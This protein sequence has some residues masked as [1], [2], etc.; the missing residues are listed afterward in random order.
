MAHTLSC[1]DPMSEATKDIQDSD[2][3]ASVAALIGDTGKPAAPA[4]PIAPSDAT[5][6][7][8]AGR[9]DFEALA[10]EAVNL[11][12]SAMPPEETAPPPT[13]SVEESLA[14]AAADLANSAAAVS[15]A[16]VTLA[17]APPSESQDL[18]KAVERL[19]QEAPP[20]PAPAPE[21]PKKI[22]AL[23]AQIANLADD[24][25]AGEF[26][27]EQN[28]LQGQVGE[29]P[30]KEAP[31]PPLGAEQ[32]T[33]KPAEPAPKV[34]APATL[35]APAAKPAAVAPAPAAPTTPPAPNVA[36]KAATSAAKVAAQHGAKAA[37]R[38]KPL[39]VKLLELISLPLK[40]K[41]KY[42]RDLVGWLALWTLFVS[43]SLWAYVLFFR[44]AKPPTA[45]Q[46]VA[47]AES[48]HGAAK[49]EAKG[50]HGEAK[51]GHG[52]AKGGHGEKK[53]AKAAK[54]PPAKKEAAKKDAAK[55]HGGGH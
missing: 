21:T 15:E 35:V 10:A 31:P 22:E 36:R 7:P 50:G 11:L 3:E 28:V 14:A 37:G 19:I 41:P 13:Q 26:A 46:P 43:V 18:A 17:D 44:S 6:D 2:L 32:P 38:L 39:G 49:P 55:S 25:I 30:A 4:A 34:E 29:P 24:L 1:G 33:A 54:K 9:L 20:E 52:E 27:D 40:D 8:E 23:D 53:D 12:V 47:A 51:G 16:P 45:A 42:T 48:E 5:P